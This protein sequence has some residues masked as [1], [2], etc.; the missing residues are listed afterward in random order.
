MSSNEENSAF[1]LSSDKNERIKI[2]DALYEI[3]GAYAFIDDK[4]EYIKDVLDTLKTKYGIPK[5]YASKLARGLHKNKIAEIVSEVKDLE[6]IYDILFA[7]SN[8]GN[9]KTGASLGETE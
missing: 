8:L 1:H 9:T 7:S 2:K 3:V 6:S 4:R 5:K